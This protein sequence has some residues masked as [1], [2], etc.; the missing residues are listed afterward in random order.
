MFHEGKLVMQENSNAIGGSV[1]PFPGSSHTTLVSDEL[2]RILGLLQTANPNATKVSFEFDGQ[3]HAHIDLRRIEEIS[4]VEE[5][6]RFL[7]GGCLFSDIRRG[8]T[9]NHPF[10]HR[11]SMLVAR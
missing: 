10:H 11:V 4:I 9:P 5:R 1:E 6:L 7:G 3:L 8:K 2:R